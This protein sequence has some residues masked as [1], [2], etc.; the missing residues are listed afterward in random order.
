MSFFFTVN[1]LF[2][3]KMEDFLILLLRFLWISGPRFGLAE[4]ADRGVAMNLLVAGHAR[5]HRRWLLP[6][7][8]SR[9]PRIAVDINTA[10]T[11]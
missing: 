4:W 3:E 1:Y 5:L 11:V 2:N 7:S 9:R 10:A 8:R 6:E